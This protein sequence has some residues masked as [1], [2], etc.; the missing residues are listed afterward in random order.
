MFKITSP[1]QHGAGSYMAN[2][3]DAYGVLMDMLVSST[4]KGDTIWHLQQKIDGVWGLVG[5]VQRDDDGKFYI[6]KV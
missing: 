6:D 4:T 3:H 1:D 2:Q 5:G